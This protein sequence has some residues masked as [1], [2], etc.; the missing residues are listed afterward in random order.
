MNIRQ[1]EEKDVAQCVAIVGLNYNGEY[2]RVEIELR[3][4]FDPNA[5]IRPEYYVI[6]ED[7]KV[8]AFGGFCQSCIDYDCYGIYWINVHPDFQGHGYGKMIVSKLVDVIGA[9][10]ESWAILSCKE[11]LKDFYAS[12]GF[13]PLME[14]PGSGFMM[15]LDYIR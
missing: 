3:A 2:D 6:E 13:K 7:D 5:W 10:H 9:I 8:I 11:D 14:R 4:A 15:G 12:L 1:I